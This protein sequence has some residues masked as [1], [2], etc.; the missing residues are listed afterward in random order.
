MTLAVGFY[1]CLAAAGLSF[2][3]NKNRNSREEQR[4]E[5]SGVKSKSALCGG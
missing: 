5:A 2:N 4:S 1:F 3:Q